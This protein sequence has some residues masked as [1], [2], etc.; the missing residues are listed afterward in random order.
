[1]ILA[2]CGKQ[3][4]DTPVDQH[5]A[6]VNPDA[7]YTI[8]VFG[9]SVA[10]G[11]FAD[12]QRNQALTNEEAQHFVE[13]YRLS[14]QVETNGDTFY[15]KAQAIA[16]D[17]DASAYSGTADYALS[18]R[19]A[20]KRGSP[21]GIARYAVSGS[22]AKGLDQQISMLTTDNARGLTRPT[23]AVVH[24]GANDYCAHTSLADF[25]AALNS[26][27]E[28]LKAQ[29]PAGKVV[30][31]AI[32]PVPTIL[33]LPDGASFDA[34]GLTATC[35]QIRS[36][37]KL[38]EGRPIAPGTA[39]ATLAG[40]REEVAGLNAALKAAAAAHGFTFADYDASGITSEELA[41]DCFHPGPTGHK[42]IADAIWPLIEPLVP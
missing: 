37:M 13:L 5:P 19:I 31:A 7:S 36:V 25:N 39:A 23:L 35:S 15:R 22:Q 10:S 26:S 33:S 28:N 4:D 1:M 17:P 29:L 42:R 8:A 18:T 14:E 27:F 30:V 6:R 9:D 2:A 40:D 41:V 34:L 11:M 32:P 21:T 16:A 12:T 38:C 3:N 24:I 20:A